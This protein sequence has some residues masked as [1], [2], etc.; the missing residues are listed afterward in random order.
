MPQGEVGS[1]ECMG[2]QRPESRSLHACTGTE[3]YQHM[4]NAS[5]AG[6]LC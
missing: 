2:R 1:K 3:F 6:G 5:G 4:L